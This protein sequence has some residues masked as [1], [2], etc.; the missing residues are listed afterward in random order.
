V[1]TPG[2]ALPLAHGVAGAFAAGLCFGWDHRHPATMAALVMDFER[3][4]EGAAT[5]YAFPE[6]CLRT[7][8][9]RTEG[10]ASS[11]CASVALVRF[12]ACAW[13]EWR[14]TAVWAEMLTAGASADATAGRVVVG[15]VK[16]EEWRR[17]LWARFE[18]LLERVAYLPTPCEPKAARVVLGMR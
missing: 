7:M 5:A 10:G 11:L 13:R 18:L 16:S 8:S 3:D 14:G 17:A 15:P 2:E 12:A 9:A 1:S 4:P 6:A